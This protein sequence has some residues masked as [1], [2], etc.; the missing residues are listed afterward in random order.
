MKGTSM[1]STHVTRIAIVGSAAALTAAT[2]LT[3]CS[4]ASS[5][6][7]AATAPSAAAP[8]ASADRGGLSGE[9]VQLGTGYFLAQGDGMQTTVAYDA[10][11]TF[12]N[13][14]SGSLADVTAGSCITAFGGSSDANGAGSSTMTTVTVSQPV[15]GECVTGFVGAGQFGGAGSLPSGVPTDRAGG[16][17]GGFPGGAPSGG[18]D[19]GRGFPTGSATDGPDAGGGFRGMGAVGEVTGVSGD[20]ITVERTVPAGATDGTGASSAPT[21]STTTVTVNASTTY[22]VEKA[23]DSSAL[24]VGLCMTARGTADTSGGYAAT[25]IA[26]SPKGANGC[27]TATGR[28]GFRGGQSGSGT[29]TGQNG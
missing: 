22:E 9:I 14:V 2:A 18:P 17:A 11:T 3:G 23:A 27:S 29:T 19:G 24:A 8:S 13:A 15:D 4:A 5:A 16:T 25:S 28:G 26:L 6:P 10:S 12:T 21:S 1:Q 7:A 20:T